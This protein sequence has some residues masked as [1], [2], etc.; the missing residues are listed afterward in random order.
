MVLSRMLGLA[1]AF[2]ALNGFAPATLATYHD[3][4][5]SSDDGGSTGGTTDSHDGLPSNFYE[6][7]GKFVAENDGLKILKAAVEAYPA[8]KSALQAESNGTLLAPTDV[9][10]RQL[11]EAVGYGQDGQPLRSAAD[12]VAIEALKPIMEDVLKMHF[13]NGPYPDSMYHSWW[14]QGNNV[15]D[16]RTLHGEVTLYLGVSDGSYNIYLMPWEQGDS[17]AAVVAK[18][19]AMRTNDSSFGTTDRNHQGHIHTINSVLHKPMKFKFADNINGNSDLTTVKSA[20]MMS[21]VARYAVLGPALQ[22]A[23]FAPTNA[24]FDSF[25]QSLGVEL[26]NFLENP[27][28]VKWVLFEHIVNSQ[29][30]ENTTKEYTTIKRGGVGSGSSVMVQFNEEGAV[31]GFMNGEN[32]ASVVRSY[33]PNFQGGWVYA[34]DRVVVSNTT[35]E[36][37]TNLASPAGGNWKKASVLPEGVTTQDAEKAEEL[38]QAANLTNLLSDSNN[39]EFNFWLPTQAALSGLLSSDNLDLTEDALTSQS[40][41]LQELMNSFRVSSEEYASD[42]GMVVDANSPKFYQT[43]NPAVELARTTDIG[44]AIRDKDSGRK[45]LDAHMATGQGTDAITFDNGKVLYFMSNAPVTDNMKTAVLGSGAG[46]VIPSSFTTLTVMIAVVV[47]L[48]GM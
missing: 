36:Y 33:G 40:E 30:L 34:V 4:G 19:D 44:I 29:N 22:G 46:Q 32:S 28:K 25:A 3:G 35:L 2:V 31:T 20:V 38:L 7:V 42:G 39:E 5:G 8:V 24:A 48:V 45:L 16:V 26:S 11:L 12:L 37:L 43:M 18:V 27:T 1:I 23:V 10:F 14:S 47:A 15:P 17:P 21:D 9:A 6:A 41:E 13:L